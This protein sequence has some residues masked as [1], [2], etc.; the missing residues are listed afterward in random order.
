MT[1]QASAGWDGDTTDPEFQR[2]VAVELA[3][4]RQER[5]AARLI[6]FGIGLI[7]GAPITLGILLAIYA[8][9]SSSGSRPAG[10]FGILSLVT[11]VA[12]LV[13]IVLIFMGA[14]R[15]ATR[16]DKRA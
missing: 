14:W 3:K 11:I 2:L 15:V 16:S 6:V 5:P 7:V 13:G 10:L 9:L 1:E 12:F 4:Q 8:A